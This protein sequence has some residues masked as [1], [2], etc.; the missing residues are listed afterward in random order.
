MEAVFR[1]LDVCHVNLKF[2]RIKTTVMTE[3]SEFVMLLGFGD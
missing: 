1:I 2:K 3:D